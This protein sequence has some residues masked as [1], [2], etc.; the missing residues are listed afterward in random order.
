MA[1]E[2]PYSNPDIKQTDVTEKMN[3]PSVKLSQVINQYLR[4]NFS[5][6]I[7]KYRIE[8]IVNLMQEKSSSMYTP[9][10]LAE[11]CGFSSRASFFRAIKNIPVKL[12]AEF[13]RKTK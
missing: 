4:T 11:K 3:I 13:L 6:Y 8:E 7:N 10:A 5:D 1:S 2:K 9:S 12:P